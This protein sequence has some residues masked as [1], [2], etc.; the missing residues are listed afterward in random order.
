M[1]T[2][3]AKLI[4]MP[5]VP[6]DDQKYNGT[7][8]GLHFFIGNIMATH[9]ALEEFWFGWRVKRIFH[10]IEKLKAYCQGHGPA[11]D[12]PRLAK[13]HE[14]RYWLQGKYKQSENSIFL[15]VSLA[16]EK[17]NNH[18][19]QFVI[20]MKKGLVDFTNLFLDWLSEH[21]LPL[22]KEQRINMLWKDKINIKGLE[23]LGNA[24]ET[25]YTSYINPTSPNTVADIKLFEKAVANSPDS[26]LTHDLLAWALFKKQDYNSAIKAFKSALSF[27]QYGLGALAG[28]MWCAISTENK[29][30]AYQ[31]AIAKADVRKEDPEKAKDFVTRKLNIDP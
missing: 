20:S 24:L 25:T 6:K 11:L 9:T 17:G 22:P 16:D 7:G 2:K 30:E 29:D 18:T 3:R 14:V 15:S 19:T 1:K 23:C 21:N 13:E 31:Y 10:E 5:F 8:L 27:N 28:L 12:I 4:V 26:Y